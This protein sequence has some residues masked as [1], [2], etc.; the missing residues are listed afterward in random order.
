MPHWLWCACP[1]AFVPLGYLLAR[2]IS[3]STAALT[4]LVVIGALACIAMALYMIVGP[5]GW[6]VRTRAM[7]AAWNLG[8]PVVTLLVLI[9]C[10]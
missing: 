1:P 4:L 3:Q 2:L 8:V 7:I 6:R 5:A 10:S 9:R